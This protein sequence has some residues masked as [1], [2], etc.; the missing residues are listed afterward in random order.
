[1]DDKI[2]TLFAGQPAPTTESPASMMTRLLPTAIDS[3]MALI[4]LIKARGGIWTVDLHSANMDNK[5][6]TLAT[7]IV[8]DQVINA[9]LGR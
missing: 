2:V 4:V 9:I 3:D 1:M 7:D 5:D 8:K 6:V